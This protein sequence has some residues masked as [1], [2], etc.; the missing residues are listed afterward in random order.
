MDIIEKFSGYIGAHGLPREIENAPELRIA[1]QYAALNDE[2][3]KLRLNTIGST[4]VDGKGNLKVNQTPGLTALQSRIAQ[5][6]QALEKLVS[7]AGQWGE[8]LEQNGA[9]SIFELQENRGKHVSIIQSGL[10]RAWEEFRL[11]R[12][13]PPGHGGYPE[14]LPS[15]LAKIESYKAFEDGERAKMEQAK[16]ALEPIDAALQKLSSLVTEAT[17]L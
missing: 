9:G 6:E 11:T 14:L 3:G 5:K 16:A 7:I 17:G 4:Y 1:K 10:A 12:E 15:D 13:R 2:L 8:I